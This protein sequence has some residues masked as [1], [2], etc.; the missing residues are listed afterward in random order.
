M[1]DL[2]LDGFNLMH[3]F[4]FFNEH[5][6]DSLQSE[7]AR[8]KQEVQQ[9]SGSDAVIKEMTIKGLAAFTA[10]ENRAIKVVF[11]DRTIVRM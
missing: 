6:G 1:Q 11:E 2:L 9:M 5:Q 7:V 8:T 3:N 4:M 10:F